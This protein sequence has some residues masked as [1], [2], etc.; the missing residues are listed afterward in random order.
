[1]KDR[2]KMENKVNRAIKRA[3]DVE[4]LK[5]YGGPACNFVM[6]K[7]YVNNWLTKAIK[8]KDNDVILEEGQG[9]EP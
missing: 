7:T 5:L 6:T 8:N 3:E 4:D 1:M 2:E 9:I